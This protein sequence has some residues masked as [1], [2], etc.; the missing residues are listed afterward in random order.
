MQYAVFLIAYNKLH[1][2][3]CILHINIFFLYI[4]NEEKKKVIV[5]LMQCHISFLNSFL[6]YLKKKFNYIY[7]IILLYFFVYIHIFIVLIYMV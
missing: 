4:I 5:N 1:I 3:Y 7:I 2:L 6:I